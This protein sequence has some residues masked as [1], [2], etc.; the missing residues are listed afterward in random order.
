MKTNGSPDSKETVY[1]YKMDETAYGLP[2]NS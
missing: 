1:Y 2:Y